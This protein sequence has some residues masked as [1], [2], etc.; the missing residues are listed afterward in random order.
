LACTYSEGGDKQRKAILH[1]INAIA[2]DSKMEQLKGVNDFN[3][4]TKSLDVLAFF[5]IL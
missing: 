1:F 4:E 5:K 3:V 2:D